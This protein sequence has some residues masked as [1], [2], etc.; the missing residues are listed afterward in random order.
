MAHRFGDADFAARIRLA[1]RHRRSHSSVRF[2]CRRGNRRYY[3]LC[4]FR[5]QR[6]PGGR[7]KVQLRRLRISL[8]PRPRAGGVEDPRQ[9]WWRD[10]R[11]EPAELSL[12]RLGQPPLREGQS[13]VCTAAQHPL[14]YLR[15][16]PCHRHGF[17]GRPQLQTDQTRRGSIRRPA[18]ASQSVA[19]DARRAS[20]T[21]GH[22]TGC[23]SS[24][25]SRPDARNV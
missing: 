20:Q 18:L 4:H 3:R 17:L 2:P 1:P 10:P 13:A 15:F 8:I 12:L 23:Y 25:G 22:R 24:G 5:R 14:P 16:P 9:A 7:C 6:E 11:H 21:G 19:G